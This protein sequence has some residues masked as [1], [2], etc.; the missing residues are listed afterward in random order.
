[1]FV[2]CGTI[3]TV[4]N[5]TT[6]VA[7]ADMSMSCYS[8]DHIPYAVIGYLTLFGL[9]AQAMLL[10][11]YPF[12]IFKVLLSKIGVRGQ[13]E[14]II[15]TFVE[16]FY[17]C[18]RDGLG[19]GRDMRSFSGLY[20]VLRM[21]LVITNDIGSPTV[22]VFYIFLFLTCATL[23]ISF[24]K[25]YKRILDNLI[26]T[27]V[28]TLLMVLVLCYLSLSSNI[29]LSMV[30]AFSPIV[31]FLFAYVWKFLSDRGLLKNR[32]VGKC[33]TPS[34]IFQDKPTDE[35]STLLP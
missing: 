17:G 24:F 28:L 3:Y 7:F 8:K 4:S 33:M 22:A 25:P 10:I 30:L 23:L 34:I 21:V 16:K 35:R 26:D 6:R 15:T 5:S 13:L 31:V 27:L 12:K 19:G 1:M 9:L 32:F 29:L 14:I 20:F 2:R 11:L 18:Y